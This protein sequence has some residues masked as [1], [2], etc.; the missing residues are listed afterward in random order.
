MNGKIFTYGFGDN[1]G[2][3]SMKDLLGGK[4]ANLA[5]MT[6]LDLP[7]PF[8]ITITTDVCKQYRSLHQIEREA[9]ISKYYNSMVRPALDELEAELGYTPLYSIRSGAAYSMPGMMDT[10]LNIGLTTANRHEW[11]ARL[12]GSV[13]LDCRRRQLEMYGETVEGK[14]DQIKAVRKKVGT[15]RYGLKQAPGKDFNHSYKHVANYVKRLEEIIFL[16]KSVDDQILRSIKAVFKSWDSERA[17]AY[18]KSEGIDNDLGTAVNI[19]MM[20][21]G[22]LN[23]DSASGVYFTR[24]PVDGENA[25]YGDIV[26]GGQ[27]EDVVAGTHDTLKVTDLEATLPE[28]YIELLAIGETLEHI[29]LDMVDTEFTI[30]DGKLWMLQ[31]RIG[32]REAK[33]AFRIAHDL[34]VEGLLDKVAAVSRVTAK[35]YAALKKIR[36]DLDE[37]PEADY[38]GIAAGGSLVVGAPVGSSNEAKALGGKSPVILCTD[39]TTPNDFPGMMAS[40]GILT[41]TGGATSHAAVV[42]RAYEKHCVVGCSLLPDVSALPNRITL[43]GATGR[44]WLTELPLTTGEIDEY[45]KTLFEWGVENK[46]GFV[47]R[48]SIEERNVNNMYINASDAS[49]NAVIDFLNHVAES[50]AVTRV[51]LDLSAPGADMDEKADGLL[52]NIAGTTEN[53]A[54]ALSQARIE[55]F[56]EVQGMGIAQK[57]AILVVPYGTSDAT[58]TTLRA[59]GWKVVARVSDLKTLFDTDGIVEIDSKFTEEVGGSEI[60]E[61][62]LAMMAKA[63]EAVE[64][65]PTPISANRL[66]FEVFNS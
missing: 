30:E 9:F 65:V 4:G 22:N 60:A 51:F 32:Q 17:V 35:Q 40:V 38:V 12:G 61:K 23:D 53:P 13:R 57:K 7:V 20:V 25:P 28:A 55:D 39:E 50:D 34:C 11:T 2:D 5:E 45:A 19:Q 16:P 49:L 64:V 10:L 48:G 1:V 37:I 31:V 54:H 36:I 52:W 59:V 46:D 63:G 58:I 3:K 24:S 27:G 26:I 44:V 18:R 62:L 56:I 15:F 21:F 66:V 47:L 14:A 29:Y 42:G 41:R 33:A 6:N 8:G 43:D